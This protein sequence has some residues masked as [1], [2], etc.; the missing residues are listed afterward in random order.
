MT[1]G[2]LIYDGEKKIVVPDCAIRTYADTFVADEPGSEPLR[3]KA[4]KGVRHNQDRTVDLIVVHWTASERVGLDGARR[5]L[6]NMSARKDAGCHLLITNEG[7]VWQLADLTRDMTTH[8][9]HRAVRRRSIGIEVSCQG[10][11]KKGRKMHDLAKAREWY[12]D[13]SQGWRPTMANFFPEQQDALN[14]V[15]VAMS[16]ALDIPLAVMLDPFRQRSNRKLKQFQGV[17]G[18]VHCSKTKS[19]PGTKTLQ[20]IDAHYKSITERECSE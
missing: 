13:K 10:W 17:I 11:V 20:A 18:H 2:A 5:T 15:C 3:F 6:F 9:G 19:D 12:R 4:P 8:V 14:R 7:T 1:D 16:L